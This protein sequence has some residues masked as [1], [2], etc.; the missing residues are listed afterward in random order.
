MAHSGNATG[1]LL[2]SLLKD[3]KRRAEKEKKMSFA[4]KLR[5]VDKLMADGIPAVKEVV[6]D[7]VEAV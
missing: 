6:E 4:R 3:Q 5:V 2:E 1:R 7:A